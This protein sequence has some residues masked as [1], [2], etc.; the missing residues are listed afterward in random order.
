[1]ID[2][3]AMEDELSL[4]HESRIAWVNNCK[5]VS[6]LTSLIRRTL[7]EKGYK[8]SDLPKLY[9]L[10]HVIDIDPIEYTRQHSMLAALRVAAKSGSDMLHGAENAHSLARKHLY[11]N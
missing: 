7:A 1:M 6:E 4:G 9:Q 8:V 10:A 11:G 2:V 5:S 3:E